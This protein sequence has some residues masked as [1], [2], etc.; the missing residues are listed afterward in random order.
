MSK[1]PED[2]KP[3]EGISVEIKDPGIP[4]F[5]IITVALS[6]LI[7]ITLLVATIL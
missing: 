6:L 5:G 3:I 4:L 7:W 2:Y 1:L